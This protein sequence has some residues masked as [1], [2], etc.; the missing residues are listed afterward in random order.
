MAEIGTPLSVSL[1]A[2]L[3]PVRNLLRHAKIEGSAVE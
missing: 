1:L 2:I 3:V